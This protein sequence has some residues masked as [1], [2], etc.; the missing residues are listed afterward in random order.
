MSEPAFLLPYSFRSETVR[1]PASKS[2]A[3][4]ALI[5]QALSTDDVE[6]KNL[7]EA[8]DTETLARL[9]GQVQEGATLDCGPAGTTFRFL[10]ALLCT[11]P[12]NQTLTGS[13]R[14]LLRPI[15]PL[16]N[17]LRELGADITYVGEEG[18]PPLKIGEAPLIAS[19]KTSLPGDTSS[20]FLSAL[21]LISPVLPKGLEIEWTGELVSRPYLEMTAALMGR[22]G[23]SVTIENQTITIAPTAYTGGKYSV[24]SDW[25]AASYVAA[26]AAMSPVDTE[27]FCPLLED[28]SLQGD[29]QLTNWISEWG[30]ESTFS[31]EGL[32]FKKTSDTKPDDW[33]CDFETSPDLAQT[34]A[35]LCAC[36]G[37]IGL[38]T[39]L[40]TLSIKETDRIEALKAELNKVNVYMSKLPSKFSPNSAKTY[41]MLQEQANWEGT[42]EIA[43]YH[44]HRMA[45]AF[46][47]LGTIGTVSIEDASV[48]EKSWPGFWDALDHVR[49]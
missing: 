27:L 38:Y 47:L 41:Y 16:V 19:A 45:M 43:T 33:E 46:A 10:T 31:D 6:I 8:K 13:E 37:T 11:T 21:M 2:L 40:Q 20:Q 42:V 5:I 12:G 30:V 15:G 28:D 18:F 36:T 32:T 35:V 17:A 14:M 34:F 25:S 44:D 29:R 22:F 1:L 4:R 23:A 24:E 9:L 26:W 48:V 3:N 49:S 7:S 39:G